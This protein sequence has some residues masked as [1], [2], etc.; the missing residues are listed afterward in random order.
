MTN[1]V[2]QIAD[3]LHNC[4]MDAKIFGAIS[5]RSPK[6]IAATLTT[7]ARGETLINDG[8]TFTNRRDVKGTYCCTS[9]EGELYHLEYSKGEL[10]CDCQASSWLGICKHAVALELKSRKPQV[11]EP[12]FTIV[13][14]WGSWE[15]FWA[16]CDKM[17]AN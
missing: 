17:K 3:A 14:D 7:I 5:A 4:G 1:I 10:T 12:T 15:A 6:A 11:T 8:Y 9:P 13:K 16:D 2:T